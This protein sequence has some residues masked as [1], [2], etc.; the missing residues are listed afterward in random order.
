MTSINHIL[1]NVLDYWKNKT[2]KKKNMY[3]I[4]WKKNHTIKGDLGSTEMIKL[5]EKKVKI[6]MVRNEPLTHLMT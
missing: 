5:L 6:V 4:S 1:Q 3:C 2:G